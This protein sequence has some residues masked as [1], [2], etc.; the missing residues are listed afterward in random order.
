MGKMRSDGWDERRRI[1][2]RWRGVEEVGEEL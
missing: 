1:R 2:V